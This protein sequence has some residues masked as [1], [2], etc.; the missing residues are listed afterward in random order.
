MWSLRPCD[1]LMFLTIE[2]VECIQSFTDILS[3]HHVNDGTPLPSDIMH[4][5]VKQINRGLV[6]PLQNSIIKG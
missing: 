5:L 3:F 6:F 1:Q 2:I 4:V